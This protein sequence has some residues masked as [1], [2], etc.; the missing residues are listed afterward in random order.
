[1]TVYKINYNPNIMRI[2]IDIPTMMKALGGFN[3]VMDG[4]PRLPIWQTFEGKLV[5]NHGPEL[6]DITVWQCN[7]C[8]S[9]KAYQACK[10]AL[11]EFGEF[12]PIIIDNDIWHIFNI[13]HTLQAD[14][15]KS[16]KKIVNGKESSYVES[17]GFQP[18]AKDIVFKS[19]YD[20]H[21]GI[22][23]QQELIDLLAPFSGPEFSEKL[24]ND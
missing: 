3:F 18:S 20:G 2:E 11:A 5:A 1:M 13:T 22:Y 12:L 17:I 6:A 14:T 4:T 7:P 21:M 10:H 8:F 9:P 23:C 16:S 15:S 24:H 19:P